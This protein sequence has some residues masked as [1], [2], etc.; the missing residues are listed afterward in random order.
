M[1]VYKLFVLDRNT[2]DNMIVYKLIVLDWNTWNHRIVAKSYNCLQMN[3]IS[4]LQKEKGEKYFDI[5]NP[6]KFDIP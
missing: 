3:T 1:I 6:T 4:Y 5:Y 2:W